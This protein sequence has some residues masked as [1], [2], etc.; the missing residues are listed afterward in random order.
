VDHKPEH[1]LEK[2]R[3]EQYRGKVLR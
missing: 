1:P 3:I 2:Q